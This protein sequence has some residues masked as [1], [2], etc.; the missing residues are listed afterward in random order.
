MFSV[1]FTRRLRNLPP[2]SINRVTDLNCST[3]FVFCFAVE[4]YV[5]GCSKLFTVC[6]VC[7]LPCFHTLTPCELHQFA[8][9][10]SATW[11]SLHLVETRIHVNKIQPV[12]LTILIRLWFQFK[13][14][15]FLSR[16]SLF[17]PRQLCFQCVLGENNKKLYAV[18]DTNNLTIHNYSLTAG[19]HNR[20][21]AA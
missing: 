9:I 5:A 7:Y 2:A 11:Y 8:P 10:N 18:S 17:K 1:F 6:L 4:P 15:D 14:L 3:F 19:I 13:H 21:K 12:S 16:Y 20:L